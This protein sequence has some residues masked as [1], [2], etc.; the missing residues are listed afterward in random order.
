MKCRVINTYGPTAPKAKT[1]PTL[2]KTFYRKL[3]QAIN[4][5]SKFEI[6]ILG[7]FNAR[8]GQLSV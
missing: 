3:K 2:V 6:F 8:L 7:D 4:V 5:P 1:K